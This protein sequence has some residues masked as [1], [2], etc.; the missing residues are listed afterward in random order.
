M[1]KGL[2]FNKCPTVLLMPD[3][4][5]LRSPCRARKTYE[6]NRSQHYG[7]FALAS[8]NSCYY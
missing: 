6:R 2:K 7:L 1:A 4:L 3:C 5:D 8:K